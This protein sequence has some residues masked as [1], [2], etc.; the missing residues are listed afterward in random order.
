MR[1]T[2]RLR[3]FAIQ[4]AALGLAIAVVGCGGPAPTAEVDSAKAAVDKAASRRR[5]NR[6]AADSLKAAEAARAALD[7]ELKAQDSKWIKFVRQDERARSRCDRR[8]GTRRRPT[9]SRASEK[10]DAAG[11]ETESGGGPEP[12]PRRRPSKVGGQVKSPTKIKDVT[13]VYPE[14]AKSA[15]VSGAVVLEATIGADGKV[16]DTRVV[17]SVPLLDDAAVDAV[18]QWEYTPALLNGAPVPVLMTSHS[19]SIPRGPRAPLGQVGSCCL[20]AIPRPWF[21]RAS[22]SL[23]SQSQDLR[24]H[25]AHLAMPTFVHPRPGRPQ[26]RRPCRC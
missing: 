22:L 8:Q 2:L 21:S 17:H 26:R 9:R 11:G 4:A 23:R 16:I 20:G 25:D 24:D 7:A 3:A 19:P 14:I 15:R 10:A 12:R 5:G 6:Y 13:P 1:G 18:R